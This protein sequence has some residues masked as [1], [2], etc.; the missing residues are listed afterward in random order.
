MSCV[1][2]KDEGR[3]QK[4]RFQGPRSNR[5]PMELSWCLGP[6]KGQAG[7]E[8]VRGK[9]T[10][11]ARGPQKAPGGPGI[12]SEQK[13]VWSSME[14]P[15]PCNPRPIARPLPTPQCSPHSPA[16]PGPALAPR[17]H[18]G[19]PLAAGRCLP[20]TGTNGKPLACPASWGQARLLCLW[21]EGS[22]GDAGPRSGAVSPIVLSPPDGSGHPL[23]GMGHT[24][25]VWPPP[26][27]LREN[28]P[29]QRPSVPGQRAHRSLSPPSAPATPR[30]NCHHGNPLPHWLI[31][32]VG[33]WG[34]WD[35]SRR[36]DNGPGSWAGLCPAEPIPSAPPP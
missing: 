11:S 15:P 14:H 21:E 30:G 12:K 13:P 33:A 16:P 35:R 5:P 8:G 28:R 3:S 17:T 29:E 36:Q 27:V 25:P 1:S 10:G 23:P 9:G 31:A 18:R 19:C 34:A 4:V 6:C 26:M 24:N 32:P 20:E 22:Q 7:A 2:H